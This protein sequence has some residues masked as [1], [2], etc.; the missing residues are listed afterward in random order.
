MATKYYVMFDSLV[1]VIKSFS[2]QS[3][4]KGNIL[5]SPGSFGTSSTNG[6]AG[7]KSNSP[8]S[9]LVS[10]KYLSTYYMRMQEI[11]DYE[12]TDLTNTII[13]IYKDYIVGYFNKSGDLITLSEQVPNYKF[14]QDWLNTV[15]KDLD[16]VNE[17]K[18]HLWDI[19]YDGAWCFKIAF[20]PQ[21]GKYVKFY[22]QNPHNV[23]TVK[24]DRDQLC[25]L[26]VSR[27]G[28][29]Y[30]VLP[31]SIFRIGKADLS[32]INDVNK[33]FWQTQKEDTLVKDDYMIA[34]YPL[35]YN[36]AGKVK[37]Y[38]LKEQI[39]SLLSIKDLIQP[40]LLLVR[41]DKNTAPDEGNRL[42][43]NIE[44]MINKYS[45]ISS[46]LGSNFGINSLIDSLMNNIRVIPDY[47]SSMGDMN[48]IDLSKITNKINEIENNQENKKE[49][50]LT[51]NSIPRSLYNGESTKWDAIK[52]SQRLNSKVNGFV[53]GIS[54]SIKIEVCKLYKSR[55]GKEL[56]SDLVT[57]NLF[58]KTDVDYNVAITN[59]EIVSQLVDGIQ[60]VLMSCQQTMQEVKVIDPEQY[61]T[62]VLSQLKI[63]DPDISKFMDD[64]TIKDYIIKL[65]KTPDDQDRIQ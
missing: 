39:L 26:V 31:D 25:H 44:N 65:S 11:K 63:I 23:V 47:Q 30:E 9:N 20:D 6:L 32:L 42:A 48:S 18:D 59:T 29:I 10:N 34:G 43:L 38:L 57:V 46:I 21:T 60:R 19:L 45:D 17:V 5:S 51:S 55:T 62:F 3:V 33:D 4:L 14:E 27:D 35:Y 16:V 37:E 52:S 15:L 22:L 1:E 24:R 41:L 50:I 28:T 13:T 56:D 61:A 12:V 40:L 2:F 8:A 53:V 49:G 36:I 54:D 64:K 58:T 7:A